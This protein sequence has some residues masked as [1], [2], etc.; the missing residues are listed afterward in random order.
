MSPYKKKTKKAVSESPHPAF[1]VEG[2]DVKEGEDEPVTV[3]EC[4]SCQKKVTIRG[5][6]YAIPYCSVHHH[7][8]RR[9]K[10]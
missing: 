4:F 6:F 3:L 2:P 1:E 9:E 8:M 10:K 7:P 5:H